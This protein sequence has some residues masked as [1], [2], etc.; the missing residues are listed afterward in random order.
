[1]PYYK[2]PQNKLYFLDDAG[3]ASLL[4]AGCVQ[5]TAAEADA[6][7]QPPPPPTIVTM[8][9][10]RI[11]LLN[12]GLLTSVS[13]AIAAMTGTAGDAARIEW[14]FSPTLKRDHPLVTSL[15]ASLSLS[16]TQLDSLFTA[17]SI[18]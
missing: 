14:E 13:N 15:S 11:A 12:A 18:L 9:Q 5:I 3:H 1:M 6:L 8:R 2:D 10:G 7:R 4:P 16:S 17:A